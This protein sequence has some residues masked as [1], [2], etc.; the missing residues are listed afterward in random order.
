MAVL[1]FPYKTD[2]VKVMPAWPANSSCAEMD[3]V[4]VNS[5]DSELFA[6]MRQS[7]EYFYN[8][9]KK[10]TCNQDNWNNTSVPVI[11]FIKNI[12]F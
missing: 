7:I 8:Y 12:K 3:S 5:S 11:I 1:N 9:E 10:E 4:H 6:A 2:I